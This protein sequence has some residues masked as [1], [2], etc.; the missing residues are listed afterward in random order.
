M[1]HIFDPFGCE[2]SASDFDSVDDYAS[3]NHKRL[4][5]LHPTCS[6][7]NHPGC[8]ECEADPTLLVEKEEPEDIE[9]EEGWL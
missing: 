5:L 7:V 2:L 3:P 6:D 1:R 8:A 4:L 9:T